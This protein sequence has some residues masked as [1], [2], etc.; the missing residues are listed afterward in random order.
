MRTFNVII[1]YLLIALIKPLNAQLTY[2]WSGSAGSAAN[3]EYGQAIASD[4][5]GNV[6]VTGIFTGLVDFDPGVGTT[7]LTSISGSQDI[8]LAKYDA[9]GNF[10]WVKQIAGTNTERPFDLTADASGVYLAGIF[11]GTIDFDPSATTNS[12]TSLGGGPDGD[13][14][15][16]KYDVNG[17]LLWRDRIGSTGNDRVIGIVVDNSQNVYVSGF[18]GA[19]A[20]MDPGAGTVTFPVSGTYNAF[21]GKYSSTGAYTF[22]KQIV[23]G[24]SEADDINI[25]AAGNIYLTGSYAT[26]NDFDPN[27]GTANLSTS[28]LTQLD[29]FLAK[30]TPAGAYTYAKQIGGTG[31]DIGFGVVPD[32]SGN[33]YLGGVF[34]T[35]CDFNP[36]V[37]TFTLASAGQ[38]DLFVSKYDVNGNLTWVNGTGGTTNDYCYGLGLD[39]SNNVYITGKFQ[40]TNIDFDPSASSAVLTASSSTMYLAGYTSS[41]AYLFANMPGNITSE[42]RGIQVNTSVYVTGMF[43]NTCDFDFSAST[44]MLTSSGSDDVF[45]AKYNACVG[46]PPNQPSS[47]SGNT[48]LCAGTS[49]TY[50]VV[51][52]PGATSYTWLLPSGTTGS[53]TT[54]TIGVITGSISGTISVTANNACG[55][56]SAS[57]LNVTLNP[58][59]TATAGPSQTI[60]CVSTN[61]NLTG[62]GVS[63]Y[64]WSGPGIVSGGNT[65]S[66]VVNMAGTYSLVGSTGGCNS[67]TA[68]VNVLTNTIAPTVTAASNSSLICGPPFQG[69]ATL[70]ATGSAATYSWM[71]SGSGASISVS[72][73]VTTTYSVIATGS[74]GC[75]NMAT[76]IQNVSTCTGIQQFEVGSW[77]LEVYP[78]PTSGIVTIKAKAGLQ[79]HVYNVTGEL[80]LNTELKTEMAEINLTDQAN[81]IYL[82]KAG[83]GTKKII[84][85]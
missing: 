41:G 58:T 43:R 61:V 26:S 18:I 83:S 29:I 35:V 12:L 67:N 1:F 4:P 27:A 45:F 69:T 23:G 73:S 39:G 38:G 5:S 82:I 40:G 22:A 14:F 37:A 24:Y 64:T 19:N 28:S 11:M 63:T 15:F 79:I 56:S 55:S 53:S 78:N 16:A 49:Q 81:G 30:Y 47:V 25:D 46:S 84:K 66:P 57:T 54:N 50:S 65:S 32:A 77:Q 48:F 2:Q 74:N 60:T 85:E 76:I 31:V 6:Y 42:G 13:G 44:A 8:F 7:T 52:D 3:S 21:F 62:S 17:A 68:T 75:T 51:N 9:S 20:D 70:T 10:I 72:P 33:V 80:I 34:S 36:T 71:P 59:P